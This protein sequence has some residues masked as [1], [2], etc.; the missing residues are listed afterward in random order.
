[1]TGSQLCVHEWILTLHCSRSLN[2]LASLCVQS[3]SIS[4]VWW[5]GSEQV[6]ADET[7][8]MSSHTPQYLGIEGCGLLVNLQVMDNLAKKDKIPAPNVSVI[9]RFH[10]LYT[11]MWQ[12]LINGTHGYVCAGVCARWGG[13]CMN[14]TTDSLLHELLSLLPHVGYWHGSDIKTYPWRL[15]RGFKW[16]SDI[17]TSLPNIA[18]QA[19]LGWFPSRI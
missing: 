16:S 6:C 12:Y 1:M 10:S 8:H 3:S 11:R 5:V 7:V 17:V 4:V 14:N 2:Q 18:W 19:Y 15:Q 9:Q 13:L